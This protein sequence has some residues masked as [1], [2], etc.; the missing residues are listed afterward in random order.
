[1]G[2]E[3]QVPRTVYRCTA[4]RTLTGSPVRSRPP[5]V[6][7]VRTEPADLA[8]KRVGELILQ[9]WGIDAESVDY[10]PV[11]LGSHHWVGSENGTPK[12][13][14]TGDQLTPGRFAQLEGSARLVREL[15][16]SGADFVVAP[17]RGTKGQL[18]QLVD[19]RWALHALPYVAGRS[20]A[21]G[22]SPQWASPTEQGTAARIVGWLHARPLPTYVRHWDPTPPHHA[23]LLSALRSVSRP[24]RAPSSW[25]A[26]TYALL[27]TRHGVIDDLLMQYNG[28]VEWVRTDADPW[29]LTHGEPDSDNFIRADDGQ[30]L[31][32]DW[33][34]VAVAPRERDLF[35]VLQ[36]PGDVLAEYQREA[37]PHSARTA[38]MTMIGLHWRLSHLG[39]DLARLLTS[40]SDED[41]LTTEWERLNERLE[42]APGQFTV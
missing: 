19:R 36:G 7:R 16:D 23:Q 5:S 25:A 10:A 20:T 11:G 15:A 38:A 34:T 24:W 1:V 9:H 13:F 29:V 28:L 6:Q 3:V 39:H 21:Q 8:S 32:I 17:L 30:L 37:G 42:R 22:W 4:S 2:R 14:I 41:D 33:T 12:W 18:V 26:Q 35:D 27:S 40:D 31:L